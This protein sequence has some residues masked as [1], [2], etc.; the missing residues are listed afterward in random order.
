MQVRRRSCLPLSTIFRGSELSL[1]QA[2]HCRRRE[3]DRDNSFQLT[4]TLAVFPVVDRRLRT[5]T[6]WTSVNN[7]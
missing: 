3:P 5:I 6:S 7:G 4:A 2:R 1:S